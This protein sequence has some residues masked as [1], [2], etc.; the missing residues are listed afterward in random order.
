[1]TFIGIAT[2][3]VGCC[4]INYQKNQGKVYITLKK[5]ICKFTIIS[6]I[7]S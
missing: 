5:K 3:M 2:G 7:C 6:R 1:M 4:I